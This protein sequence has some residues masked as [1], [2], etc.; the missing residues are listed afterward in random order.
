MSFLSDIQRFADATNTTI[1][2]SVRAVR[3]S[4]VKHVIESTPVATGQA[5]GS[6]IA[7]IDSPVSSP[8]IIDASPFGDPEQAIARASSAINQP[9]DRVFYFTSNLPHIKYLEDGGIRG[10]GPKI[11]TTG[12]ST[13]APH[14]MFKRTAVILREEIR[15]IIQNASN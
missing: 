8:D 7:S 1:D 5:K 2:H 4:A 15:S 6:I 3:L 12:H 9:S 10:S 11:T 13:Q 14:G